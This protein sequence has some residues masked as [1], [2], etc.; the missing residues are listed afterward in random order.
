M[1]G[2]GRDEVAASC[3]WPAQSR[4][5]MCDSPPGIFSPV[6]W[7]RDILGMDP[8]PRISTTD[9]RI[10]ILFFSLGTS[11]PNYFYFLLSFLLITC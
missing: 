4:P 6:L 1:L 2:A 10:R 3:V 9:F 7:I 5:Q 8:D 11:K